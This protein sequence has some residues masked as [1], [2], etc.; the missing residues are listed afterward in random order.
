MAEGIGD[1]DPGVNHSTA[2]L[3]QAGRF[4][5]LNSTSGQMVGRE[6]Q[7]GWVTVDRHH[8]RYPLHTCCTPRRFT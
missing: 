7:E 4:S 8:G 1:A 3:A 6:T 2:V 5:T